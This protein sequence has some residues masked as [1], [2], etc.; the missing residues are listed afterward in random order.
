M[1]LNHKDLLKL[2]NPEQI[3]KEIAAPVLCEKPWKHKEECGW[4]GSEDTWYFERECTK[5]HE[6]KTASFADDCE[7]L[8]SICTVPDPPTGS[9]ADWSYMLRDLAV[10]KVGDYTYLFYLRKVMYENGFATVR[11]EEIA[12]SNKPEHICTAALLAMNLIE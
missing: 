7:Q 6:T 4:M 3:I 1:K 10:E 8:S 11:A 12:G 2:N 9:L 5:C